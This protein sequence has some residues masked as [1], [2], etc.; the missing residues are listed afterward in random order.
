MN[1][2]ILLP[3]YPIKGSRGYLGWST[4]VLLR[5]EGKW[6][7]FDTASYGDRY[8]LIEKLKECLPL[9]G[10]IDYVVL[11]HLHFDHALNVDLFPR[12][13]LV[14][15]RRE[16]E[17][18]S[19]GEYREQEDPFISPPLMEWLRVKKKELLL[20]EDG[21]PLTKNLSVRLLPGHT[22]G[23]LGLNLINEKILLTG[24]AVKN[25]AEFLSA[26]PSYLFASMDE[27]QKSLRIIKKARK[28]IP[29]HDVPLT[30]E[31]GEITGWE[32]PPEVTLDY[33][34]LREELD[35]INL[36][37]QVIQPQF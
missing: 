1:L 15:S 16:W 22:P 14:L 11:S 6:I 34:P 3:G 32:N 9:G 33:T 5:D 35:C 8:L 21:Q 24:D 23:S 2:N 31:G 26:A 10:E 37:R 30:L 17:Y 36:K 7:L 19:D 29:G 12:A 27:W 18:A 20:L 13:R 28:I 25:G 4:V